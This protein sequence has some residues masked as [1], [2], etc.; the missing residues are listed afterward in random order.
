MQG[1]N[2]RA[3]TKK[4]II[5]FCRCE[6][7]LPSLTLTKIWPIGDWYDNVTENKYGVWRFVI[8]ATTSSNHRSFLS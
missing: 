6:H 1:N 2:L 8:K 7:S 5:F 3:L 4:C